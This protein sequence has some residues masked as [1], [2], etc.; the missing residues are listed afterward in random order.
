MR[1]L[2][3]IA[4]LFFATLG[5]SQVAV[6]AGYYNAGV[7]Y[8]YSTT[9]DTNNTNVKYSEYFDI[10]GLDNQTIYLTY[11]Y[12]TS[13]NTNDS[14]LIIIQGNLSPTMTLNVDTLFLVGSTASSVKQLTLTPSGYAPMYRVY[15]KNYYGGALDQRN[16]AATSLKINFYAKATDIA[17]FR[18]SWY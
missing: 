10:S 2:F 4:L 11:D 12:V 9:M 5:F 7:S 16:A 15:M 18:K 8:Y 14:I 3:L 13:G 1:K 17:P 6:N